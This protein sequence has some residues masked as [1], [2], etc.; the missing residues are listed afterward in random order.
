[1]ILDNEWPENNLLQNLSEREAWTCM[2]NNKTLTWFGLASFYV[3]LL[4]VPKSLLSIYIQ[5]HE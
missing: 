1:M 2:I 3:K 5:K 4:L